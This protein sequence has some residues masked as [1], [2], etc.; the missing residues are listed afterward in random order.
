MFIVWVALCGCLEC[1]N[2]SGGLGCLCGGQAHCWV[3]E[4]SGAVGWLVFLC[5]L[6]LRAFPVWGRFWWLGCV[7]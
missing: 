6:A 1:G 4:G 2:A 3:S 5:G 7:V